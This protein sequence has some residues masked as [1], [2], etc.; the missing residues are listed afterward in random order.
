MQELLDFAIEAAWEAGRITLR[1][2]QTDVD[3]EMKE[4][5]SP[6]TIADRTAELRLREMIH[7][8][9]PDDAIL[10]EEHGE[11]P[12]TSGRRWIVD[13]WFGRPVPLP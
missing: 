5:Q 6:V 3:V 12:G 4:D 8:R 11:E 10:G 7:D 9:F 1:Y 13:R 2:F